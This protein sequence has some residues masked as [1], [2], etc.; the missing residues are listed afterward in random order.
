MGI[1]LYVQVMHRG[2]DYEALKDSLAKQ[3]WKQVVKFYPQ[4]ADKVRIRK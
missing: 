1:T 4:L 3:M 2:D